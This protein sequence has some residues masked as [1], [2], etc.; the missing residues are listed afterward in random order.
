MIVLDGHELDQPFVTPSRTSLGDRRSSPN[1]PAQP[2]AAPCR[3]IRARGGTGRRR[4]SSACRPACPT[5]EAW[6]IRFDGVDP[7]DLRRPIRDA[8]RTGRLPGMIETACLQCGTP[9]HNGRGTFCRRCGLP[10]GEPPRADAELPSCPICY[11]PSTDDGRLPSLDHPGLRVD[12]VRHQ[13]EHDRHPVGDDE[14]LEIAARGRPDPDRALDGAVRDRPPLS[15]H[16]PDRGGP[17]PGPGPRR[18]RDRDDPAPTLGSRWRRSSGTARVGRG[19]RSR[20]R[21]SWSATPAVA[22]LVR[23]VRRLASGVAPPVTLTREQSPETG[24]VEDRHTQSWALVSFEPGVLARDEVVG[25]LRDRARGLAA[26]LPD[27]LLGLLAAEPSSVPGH[28]QRLARR[29]GAGAPRPPADDRRLGV[30]P[31]VDQVVEDPGV[32]LVR[33]PATRLAA[34]VGPTPSTSGTVRARRDRRA[35]PRPRRTT[36]RDDVA[37]RAAGSRPG[38]TL[39]GSQRARSMAVCSPTCGIPRALR[40]GPAAARRVPAGSARGGSRRSFERT[41]RATRAPRPS[42]GRNR[43]ARLDQPALEELLTGP[44]SRRPR[45]PSRRGRRSART[46]GRQPGRAARVRDSRRGPRP[47]PGRP[48]CRRPGSARASRI[49]VR[50][51]SGARR[52]AGRPR[53]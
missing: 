42:A 21:C 2:R 34:T 29:A 19:P 49:R 41:D 11:P 45:Y 8:S 23:R 33:E 15:R 6:E 20:G 7:R 28:D 43:R 10:Y 18:D 25:L 47:R 32:A 36:V 31:D 13:A 17:Q 40:P 9:P 26:G 48:A 50:R 37:S 46:P 38:G 27:R 3:S 12:L 1:T 16:G 51:R 39:H 30:D 44:S 53:G 24:L 14:W 52:S 22:D 5:P 4:G 35:P